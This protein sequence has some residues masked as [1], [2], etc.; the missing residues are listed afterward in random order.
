MFR[1]KI[2]LFQPLKYSLWLLQY[3]ILEQSLLSWHVIVKLLHSFPEKKLFHF[4]LESPAEI[5]YFTAKLFY[6]EKFY[7]ILSYMETPFNVS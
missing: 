4:K 3:I 6:T 2:E 7:F 5:N 1:V